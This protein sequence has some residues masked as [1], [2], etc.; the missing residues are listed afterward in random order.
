MYLLLKENLVTNI[1]QV[2][3]DGIG[4]GYNEAL[5]CVTDF[6]KFNNNN[7][8]ETFEYG[9]WYFPNKS[10]VETSGDIYISRG[11][12]V[13]RLHRAENVTTPSGVFCCE[14]P[15]ANGTIQKIFVYVID[16]IDEVTVTVT[17]DLMHPTVSS[18]NWASI[19]VG[20]VVSVLLLIAVV[21][22]IV[23]VTTIKSRYC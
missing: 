14:I 2:Q 22:T 23:T 11:R 7:I 9:N 21:V 6:H 18:P 5:L 19:S 12:G 13:V 8:N 3:I 1:S 15:D 4:D 20:V 17:V 10:L 16:Q